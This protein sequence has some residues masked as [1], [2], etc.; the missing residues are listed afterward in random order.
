MS[1][2]SWR[3]LHPALAAIA[4][5]D[6]R[7]VALA[8]RAKDRRCAFELERLAVLAIAFA[9]AVALWWCYFQR[10]EVLGLEA[11]EEA[12]DAGAI[13]LEGT[14]TLT[15][16]V[17]AL[18]GIAVGYELAIACDDEHRDVVG[19]LLDAGAAIPESVRK[20][21]VDS[22]ARSGDAGTLRRLVGRE[23]A[24]G[25]LLCEPDVMDCAIASGQPVLIDLLF[26][27]GAKLP[28][29]FVEDAVRSGSIVLAEMALGGPDAR[30]RSLPLRPRG[31]LPLARARER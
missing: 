14:W 9:G 4:D 19:V 25:S 13:G 16:I 28:E 31:R 26:E 15:L 24:L 21:I 1:L 23:P 2:F 27:H 20:D 3:Q 11:A 30:E 10:T 8:V 22:C 7:F 5:D 12:E 6:L 17:L 18:I 29:T